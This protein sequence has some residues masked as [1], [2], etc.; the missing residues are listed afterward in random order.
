[1]YN[2]HFLFWFVVKR[3]YRRKGYFATH[4]GSRLEEGLC[5]I[6]PHV[7]LTTLS[8]KGRNRTELHLLLQDERLQKRRCSTRSCNMT[9]S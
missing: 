8:V 4:W 3:L 9:L 1:M 6:I 2:S 7:P 5:R